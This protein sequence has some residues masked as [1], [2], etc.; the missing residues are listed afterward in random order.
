MNASADS[1][2]ADEWRAVA[3]GCQT[4]RV[5]WRIMARRSPDPDILTLEETAEYLRIG[6]RTLERLL[7]NGEFPPA[8][9][10]GQQWRVHRRALEAYFAVPQASAEDAKRP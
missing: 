9:K 3:V 5:A 8:V 6:R 1:R 4:R 10:V 2:A 7:A